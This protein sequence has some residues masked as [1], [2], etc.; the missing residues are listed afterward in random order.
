MKSIIAE[1]IK[2][3]GMKE[4]HTID[5]PAIPITHVFV[6]FQN[7]KIRDRFVRSANMR[8]YELDGRRIKR[9]PALEADER[10]D[11]KR[12]GYIKYAINK[13][14]GIALHWIQM[15][16]PNKSIMIDGQIIAMI[17]ASGMLR[18]NK[19]EDVDEEVQR[20]MKKWLT[21]NS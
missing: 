4:E 2:A 6:E 5:C 13:K 19:Y 8:K 16:Y 7:M 1:S 17:D 10:F 11:R 21:K 20:N 15:S 3:T 14:K 9:S 12:L 18:Y